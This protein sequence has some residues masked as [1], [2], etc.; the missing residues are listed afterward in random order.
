MVVRRCGAGR[1]VVWI[2]GLGESSTSFE[3]VVAALPQLAHTLIDLP[4]YGRSPHGD[5]WSLDE[6]A[7]RLV[8]QVRG[9]IVIGHSMG[10][11]LSVLLAERGAAAAIV[12]L[13]G[14]ISRGDCTFSG[15][16]IAWSEADFI[17]SGF[18]ELKDVVY[19]QGVDRL[20]LR[21]YHAAMCFASAAQ[22]YRHAQDLVELS[23]T[24]S[25]APRMAALTVPHLYIAGVPDGV[26]GRSREL[27]TA[28]HVSWLGIEPAGHWVYLD[29]IGQVAGAIDQFVVQCD[30]PR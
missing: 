16:A 14:N 24:E 26:C 8:P 11:V 29:Q 30:Q 28:H 10:G 20:P 27:L 17:A 21:G 3:L 4:N 18:A 23:L 9:R 13:D 5:V 7:D 12:N 25:M 6:L 1:E 19:R 22:F 2:H 15:R